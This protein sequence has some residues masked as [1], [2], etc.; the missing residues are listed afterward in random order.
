MKNPRFLNEGFDICGDQL[1]DMNPR[2]PKCTQSILFERS[3]QLNSGRPV[4]LYMGGVFVALPFH[5]RYD[6]SED[7]NNGEYE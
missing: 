1:F 5:C 4:R 7:E 3:L 2:K 6:Q